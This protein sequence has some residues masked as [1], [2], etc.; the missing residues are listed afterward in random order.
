MQRYGHCALSYRVTLSVHSQY[1]STKSQSEVIAVFKDCDAPNAGESKC[2]LLRP[3]SDGPK[4]ERKYTLGEHP[5][6]KVV[7]WCPKTLAT[8]PP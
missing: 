5:T 3:E 6:R 1:V 4:T 2:A 7:V 8:V